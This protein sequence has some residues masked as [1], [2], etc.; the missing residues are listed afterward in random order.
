M[1]AD[2]KDMLADTSPEAEADGSTSASQAVTADTAPPSDPASWGLAYLDPNILGF[3]PGSAGHRRRAKLAGFLDWLAEAM[4]RSGVTLDASAMDRLS[5]AVRHGEPFH[6]ASWASRRKPSE[7]EAR[8]AARPLAAET[9][10]WLQATRLSF[11]ID[12][13]HAPGEPKSYADVAAMLGSLD[14]PMVEYVV[15]WLVGR[16]SPR[17]IALGLSWA[18]LL[19]SIGNRDAMAQLALRLPQLSMRR[20][21]GQAM[22]EGKVLGAG[23]ARLHGAYAEYAF[24]G[25]H[26][27]AGDYLAGEAFDIVDGVEAV[28]QKHSLVLPPWNGPDLAPRPAPDAPPPAGSVKVLDRIGDPTTTDGKSLVRRFEGLLKPLRLHGGT[29]DADAV[30]AALEREFPWMS[31]AN[32]AVAGAV[33]LSARRKGPA[34]LMRPMLIHGRP[35]VGK[36]RYARRVAETCKIPFHAVGFAGANTSVLVK[37]TE[38]GW[39]NARPSL[40]AFALLESGAANPL[41]LA[42]EVDKASADT[43]NGA[44]LDVMLTLLEPE[45]SRCFHDDTLLG[46]MDCSSINWIL[47]ANDISRLSQPFLRRVTL[48]RS[49]QPEARHFPII[50]EGVL[51]DVARDL[52]LERAE[53]PDIADQKAALERAF[54]EDLSMR[55]LKEDVSR[56]VR[57]AVWRPPGPRLV[58]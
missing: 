55:K 30:W 22:D 57:S 20:P 32:E 36:S 46:R 52:R 27:A 49:G 42:D 18:H 14:V 31:E 13:T 34:F 17:E 4:R 19:A 5:H 51:D 43:R 29:A 35:G 7:P 41:I 2:G 15:R 6:H 56:N 11:E 24:H 28:A 37:G 8:A 50:W 16:H 21:R 26:R 12:F 3:A 39:S 10:G 38:R 58:E 33:A 9:V 48:V 1:S 25:P 53:L 47:T 45:T 54:A 23:W 44:P 40:P